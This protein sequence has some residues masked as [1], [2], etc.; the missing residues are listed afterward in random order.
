MP[1]AADRTPF[2]DL[3]WTLVRTDFKS[4]YHASAAGFVWAMLKPLAMFVVLL[5]VFSFIFAADPD[6]RLNLIVGLFLWDFF[7]ESTRAGLTALHAKGF[8]LSKARFP[9]WV[10]VVASAANALLTLLVFAVLV[11]AFLAAAGR[12]PS[13]LAIAGFAFYVLNLL[14]IVIGF[15]L[16]ASV[17]FLRYRDLNQIWDLALQA[18]FFLAPVVYPLGMIPERFHLWLYLWP[19]TPIIQ[20]SRQVLVAGSAPSARGHLLLAAASVASLAIGVMVFRR[21]APRAAEY[22]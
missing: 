5:A 7:N 22:L 20:F 16:A 3:L 2:G 6:Y 8:L 13:P 1:L 9:S 21:H 15:S 17:L 4:R 12:A 18:G 11:V 14:A 19:P 10:V